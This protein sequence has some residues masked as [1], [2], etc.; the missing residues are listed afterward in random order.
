MESKRKRSFLE[1]IEDNES[2]KS[3]WAEFIVWFFIY[4]YIYTVF[5]QVMI[6]LFIFNLQAEEG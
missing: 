3:K 4:I 2:E 6:Y 1:E 5:P